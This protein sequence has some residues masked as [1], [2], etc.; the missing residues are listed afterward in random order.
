MLPIALLIVLGCVA[1]GYVAQTLW[2]RWPSYA[3]APDAP[4]VP[5]SVN[6]VV[7][8]VPP[9]AIRNR[10]Q[11]RPGAHER[12]DLAFLWPS[13]AP[14]VPPAKNS[15][16]TPSSPDGPTA[17]ANGIERIFIAITSGA[18][19]LPPEDRLKV[20]YPRYAERAAS[21]RQ[22]GLAVLAFRPDSP[23]QGE[24]LIYDAAAPLE[25]V[26]RCTRRGGPAPGTCIYERRI[27]AAEITV[28]FARDWLDDWRSVK[29]GIDR[30]IASIRPAGG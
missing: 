18:G 16:M 24:D 13:L 27:G 15:A 1:A 7:F 11:R 29:A 23:Y 10:V 28:R 30:V 20:I 26:A 3:L 19:V 22:D 14:P 25:F 8:N 6:G 21:A 4:A 17:A 5:V 9:A 2:S 12:V